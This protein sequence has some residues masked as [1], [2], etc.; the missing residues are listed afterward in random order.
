MSE[1]N[2]VQEPAP[3]KMPWEEKPV[4]PQPQDAREH[5][6]VRELESAVPGA[7]VEAVEFAGQVSVVVGLE[8]LMAVL[9]A[10]K[11]LGY[12][13]LVDLTAVD[14]KD[15]PEGRFDVVY[16]LHRHADSARLRVKVRV[17]DG[18]EVPT[19]VELWPTANWMEREVFDMFGIYFANHPNLERILT[20]EGF[21]G[22]PL[23]KDFPI[24][25]V[26]TGAAVYPDIYPPGGGPVKPK[27]GA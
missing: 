22:H 23:R 5:P 17:A 21:S 7:V 19:A 24:E 14:W 12:K 3:P 16:W 20:W 9:S 25:G 26:D 18:V 8:Q 13:F 4:P 15:R 1:E 2:K 27:G 11:G 10:L 6:L